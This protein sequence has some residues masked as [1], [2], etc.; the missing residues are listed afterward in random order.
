MYGILSSTCPKYLPCYAYRMRQLIHTLI[1]RGVLKTY[2]IINAF[3]EIDRKD[4]VLPEYA[5]HAYV[6]TALP[7]GNGQTISQPTTVAIL[8]ELL[9]PQKGDTILDVGSG[10]GWTT[11]LLAV[12]VGKQG[13]VYGVERIPELVAFGRDNLKKYT[14]R[15]TKITQSRSRLGLPEHAPYN[16]ILVSATSKS[17]PQELLDQLKIKGVMV[18]PIGNAVWKIQKTAKEQFT[19]DA[20][21]GFAFVPLVNS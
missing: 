4:F 20:L 9:Q 10:S 17:V 16:R 13:S 6:D 12:I 19:K 18:L 3:Q 8:L 5:T 7:I 2:N 1:E 11:A 21:E 15:N 14:Y